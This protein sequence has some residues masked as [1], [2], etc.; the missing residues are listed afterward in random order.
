M[1]E[2]TAPPSPTDADLAACARVLQALVDRPEACDD[3]RL[4]RVGE[5][6][7]RLVRA[8]RDL[9]KQEGRQRDREVLDRAAIRTARADPLAP[10]EALP[11]LVR[12]R[13]CYVCKQPYAR[14]H[15]HYDCLCP[16]CGDLNL[17]KRQQ[18]ADLRDHVA[19][20][21]GGRI[22]IGYHVVLALL[23]AGARVEATTRFPRDAARRFQ[24]EPDFDAWSDRL[25]FH[26]LDL[27]H[28][29]TVERLGEA[30]ARQLP[31]LDILIHNAA[32]TVRRPPA[33]YRHLL[34]GEA[35]G[36]EVLPEPA[37]RLIAE[38]LALTAAERGLGDELG[39][40]REELGGLT[41]P[42]RL[43][44]AALLTQLALLPGDERFDPAQFPPGRLDADGQQIDLRGDNSWM[45]ELGEVQTVE[46]LE[47]HAVNC[48]APF[49]LTR[50]L[51]PALFRLRD[52]PGYIVNVSAMEGHFGGAAKTGRH[53]HTNMAKAALNMLTRTSA[54]PYAA[55][56][57]FMNSVDT[58]WITNE[59][60]HP[61]AEE[62]AAEGFREPLD[63]IDGAARVLDPIFVG[64]NT[65]RP[66]HGRFW[67][68][69]RPIS[70]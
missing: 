54:G 27:R 44:P 59:A 14:R 38:S 29:P 58:G 12:A 35:R 21:T 42:A 37:R 68:D 32:Q 4:T 9:R 57:V 33:F 17:Q 53:P 30:L 10:A 2:P 56:G 49:I 69:Y 24:A 64:R 5:L 61:R 67:K 13:N 65:G 1:H 8:R 28:L 63:S 36:P 20:V 3:P 15:P 19:V 11:A 60:A 43:G 23:R 34:E 26:S 31:R 50:T 39:G 45:M 18:T 46:L 41:P 6:A 70:W 52:R 25:R 7:A 62:M 47:V 66:E 22:K 51:E 16:A 40:L 48:L 55:R